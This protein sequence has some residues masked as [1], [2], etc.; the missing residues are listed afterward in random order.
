MKPFLLGLA[1]LLPLTT[2]NAGELETELGR[3]EVRVRSAAY[4]LSAGRSVSEVELP[5]RLE[6]LGYRRVHERPKAAGEFFWGDERF[7]I[8]RHA[9]RL[10]GRDEPPSLFG[11][12]LD[13]TTGRIETGL[14]AHGK[15]LSLAEPGALW[16]EPELLSE[17]LEGDR[18]A[19]IPIRLAR[20]PERVWRPVLAAEDARFFDHS[21]VDPR[22]V[23]RAMLENLKAGGVAQGGST[24]TQQLIKNRDLTPRRSLGRKASEAVRALALEA[25]YPKEEILEA[26]LNQVYLG[27]LDGVAV[28]G[29]GAAARAYFSKPAAKLELEEAA[30]LAAMI[31]GP[32]RLSPERHPE[33]VKERRD[34][35]LARMEELGWAKPDEVARARRRKIGL[36]LTPPKTPIGQHFM[37]W[38]AAV[39]REEASERIEEGRGVVIEA[40]LDAELQRAAEEAVAAG[41]AELRRNHRR[42]LKV[43]LSAALVALDAR[44]GGVLAYVGGDPRAARGGFDRARQARRQ[45]GSAIKPLL[46]LEAFEDCG[47][48]DR[49]Y[50]AAR[51]A[52]EPL[53]L[54]L[55]TGP[56]EP[57]NNDDRFRGPV[58]VRDALVDSLNV[59]FVRIARWCGLEPTAA[60]LERAG[61]ELPASP[62]PAF[63]LGAIETSPLEL[64]EAYTVFPGKGQAWRARPVARI[65][66]PKGRG[67]ERFSPKSRRVASPATAFLVADLLLDA[68]RRGIAQNAA[69]EKLEVGAKTGTTSE[70]RDAWLAGFGGSVVTVVWVGRDDGEVLGLTG[71]EA[72]APMWRRFMASAVPLRPPLQL[73]RPE[74]IVE[75]WVDPE[76]GLRV[77]KSRQGARRELFHRGELPPRDRFWRRK[78]APVVR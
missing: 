48:H 13:K 17:S 11:L 39:A 35:V 45:P 31:Q 25:D 22:S 56:W 16:L 76:T 37:G 3:S 67:I 23:A 5:R 24:I 42:L 66:R 49:L 57:A 33:R 44:T 21:G 47:G 36:R 61:L 59:P 29:L 72:A 19:R 53:R 2:A 68:A 50:P 51:V 12:A 41:L 30:L 43:P 40:E 4:P 27:H 28:H 69:P 1:F 15:R 55:P 78:T 74:G 77:G 34:W 20:L 26:Y 6:R 7:W 52:D 9:H 62:P 38:V 73:S 64:A 10:D 60:R 14:T 18:A 70:R 65:E 75:H 32:N 8:F 54:D 58:S 71:S 46:L 63:A